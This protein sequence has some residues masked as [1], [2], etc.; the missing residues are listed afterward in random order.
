MSLHRLMVRAATGIGLFA[1]TAALCAM[2]PAAAPPRTPVL[3]AEF[4]DP[5]IV[6]AGGVYHAY[7]TN[8]AGKHLQHATSRDLTHWTL[9]D[10]DVLPRLGGWALED[11]GKVWA[12]EVFARD[13][14]FTMYYTAR[15]AARDKQCVGVAVAASPD[16][17]FRPVG[18]GPL[19]CPAEQGGAID[20]A[21]YT[22]GGRRYLLWKSDGNCCGMDTWIHL[23]PVNADGTRTTGDA[24]RLIKQVEPEPG[25]GKLVEAP[26][27]VR[28]QGRYV[29]FYSAGPYSNDA[30]R[31]GYATAEHLTG[32]Y[33]HAAQPLMT[34]D[35][36]SRTV[37]GPGGQDVVTGPDGRDRIVFHGWSGTRRVMYLAELGFTD[38]RPVVRGSKVRYEAESATVHDAVVREAPEASGRRVVG[39]IDHPDS[40]VEFTVL[41]ASPGPHTLTVLFSNGSADGAGHAL[42]VNGRDAGS[43]GYPYT[44]WGEWRTVET[45]VQLRAGRN[46][47]R[48]TK[49]AHYTEIDAVDIT[50]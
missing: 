11:M 2:A 39:R 4:A 44:G 46:T 38:G 23:Q 3:D 1:V 30:Y 5:D 41:A 42:A 13:G 31:T 43:V 18:D 17:P 8:G 28:R 29:L 16:G 33:T 14:G 50:W 6:R 36:F 12:P 25:D 21:M 32:P 24:V 19:V 20:P 45:T 22:E 27:L 15:D 49:G 10:R 48:L 40:W 47:V 26:T 9:D 35:S 7:A 37:L 34:T